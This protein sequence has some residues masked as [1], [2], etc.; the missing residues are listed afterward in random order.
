MQHQ[1]LKIAIVDLYDGHF[2]QGIKSIIDI[3]EQFNLCEN[4]VLEY[5]LFDL[6]A[7]N[8]IPDLSYHGYI[9]SGGP[10]S[11]IDSLG[12]VWE[13]QF[14]KLVDDLETSNN[15]NGPNP[16]FMFYICHSF[17]MMCRKKGLGELTKRNTPAFGLY[18][19]H[20][21]DLID[22]SGIFSALPE[23]F[24]VIDSRE[25][26][27]TNISISDLLLSECK[28]LAYEKERPHVPLDR[29]VMAVQ[30]NPFSWGTQ[31]HPEVDLDQLKSYLSVPEHTDKIV[32]YF[33]ASKLF[34][35]LEAL[36]NTS[37][38]KNTKN[39]ILPSF[40]MKIRK[41]NA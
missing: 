31:F 41:A 38:L 5:T 19:A 4:G 20:K 3:I 7:K 25:W 2:N 18:N 8:E 23:Q 30:F 35:T 26:Q 27:V 28:I 13:N 29:C 40:L 14:F 6:R 12:E 10:G 24:P 1:P 33:G 11:P 17:Q 16:K 9:F 21:T 22:E 39:V 37:D 34:K 32:E 15:K 36:E